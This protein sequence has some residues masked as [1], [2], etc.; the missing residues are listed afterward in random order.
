MGAW[1]AVAVS[2]PHF[3][4][5]VALQGKVLVYGRDADIADQH[6]FRCDVTGIG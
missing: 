5:R 3:G 2:A 1:A 4:Q 6:R